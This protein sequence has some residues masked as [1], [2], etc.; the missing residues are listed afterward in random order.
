MRALGVPGAGPR[1]GCTRVRARC[2]EWESAPAG[3]R[4]HGAA[5]GAFRDIADVIGRHLNLPVTGVSGEEAE[6]DL[7]WLGAFAGLDAPASS[8][9][10]RTWLGR[11]P[12]QPGLIADLEEGLY[13]NGSKS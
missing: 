7:G 8:T 10:T 11:H 1:T 5:E 2:D 4:L 13:F 12:V 3:S 9:L 6:A